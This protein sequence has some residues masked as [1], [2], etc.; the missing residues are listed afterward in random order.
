MFWLVV[1]CC[2]GGPFWGPSWLC[3]ATVLS[4]WDQEGEQQT[5]SRAYVPLPNQSFQA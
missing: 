3:R 4:R 5:E 2:A 1:L